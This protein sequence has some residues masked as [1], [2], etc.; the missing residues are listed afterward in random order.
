MRK[1]FIAL[2]AAV[3]LLLSVCA[4]AEIV[5]LYSKKLC[6]DTADYRCV[7]IRPNQSWRS[8]FPD[9]QERDIVKRVNRMNITLYTGLKIAVPNHLD[10]LS[11]FDV[12]PFPRYI[13]PP[14]EKVIFVSQ[15]ELAFGAYD[16]DGEL[17][18]WGPVSTGRDVCP[19]EGGDCT[20][21]AGDYRIIR[22]QDIDCISTVF[23]KNPDGVD[24]GAPMPYCMHFY[25]GFALHGSAAVPGHRDSHGCVRMFTEDAR[26]LNL[27]FIQVTA[28]RQK[29]TRVIIGDV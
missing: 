2:V 3:S 16:A 10:Q 4:S 29:G 5:H 11:I 24:G 19:D 12:S 27:D 9:P 28:G 20:T 21:P 8:L 18:W 15:R 7:R 13:D 1:I 17:V 26:W 25:S 22:K 6:A 14:G 23:P